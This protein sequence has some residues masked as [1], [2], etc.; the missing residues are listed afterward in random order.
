ML[1]DGKGYALRVVCY[2]IAD[3][4]RRRRV[5]GLLEGYGVRVQESVF[6]C[7]IDE[8][9]CRR[10]QSELARL[11]AGDEDKVAIY[12]TAQPAHDAFLIGGTLSVD[13]SALVL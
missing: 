5:V 1:K 2:D 4:R 13:Q 9:R 3:D 12:V 10:L 7:W 11:I 8:P 6:E